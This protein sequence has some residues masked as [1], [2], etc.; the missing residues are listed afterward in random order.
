M[1]EHLSSLG[2]SISRLKPYAAV[3]AILPILLC[4]S[5]GVCAA[6]MQS[7]PYDQADDSHQIFSEFAYVV[8]S[9]FGDDFSGYRINIFTGELTTVP[10]SPFLPGPYY[11]VNAAVAGVAIDS[12][13]RFL[14]SASAGDFGGSLILGFSIETNGAL[15]PLPSA[16]ARAG[17]T[18]ISLALD[19]SNR[20][21]YAAGPEAGI[22]GYS[23]D[24]T[25]GL[26]TPVPGS[27]YDVGPP[28]GSVTIDPTGRFVYVLQLLGPGLLG[29]KIDPSTGALTPIPGSPFAGLFG[30]VTVDPTGR[31]LYAFEGIGDV[32][33]DEYTIDQHT[34]ALTL[35]PRSP[36]TAP[37]GV[38][39]AA[40]DP[41]GRFLYV[42]DSNL[43]D[44]EASNQIVGFFINP[45]SGALTPLPG[46][47]VPIGPVPNALTVDPT[48]RFL[49]L[50]DGET[51]IGYSIDPLSGAL[52]PLAGSPVLTGLGP[53]GIA[54]GTFISH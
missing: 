24:A 48:G 39:G 45:F 38:A 19:P 14:Y 32:D 26:L 7:D 47:P 52:R 36:F 54:V 17:G 27:P 18:L 5:R 21:L 41:A 23:V 4:T 31:F 6:A 50:V 33:I 15:T 37:V 53:S 22:V 13:D 42:W 30:H 28:I 20:F 44:T 51:V 46:A 35:S 25:T 12:K 43:V 1:S 34:G 9:N 2:I 10:G 11:E 3:A 8:N 40:V 49:Y 16:A 29:Y